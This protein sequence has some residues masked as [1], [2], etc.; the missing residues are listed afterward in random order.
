MATLQVK[1]L[2]DEL[3]QEL[4]NRAQAERTTMSELV[5]SMLTRELSRPSTRQ[6]VARVRATTVSD[7]SSK[8]DSASVLGSLRDEYGA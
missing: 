6:W 8:I 2:P 5:T 3:H 7:P 1:N 4:A